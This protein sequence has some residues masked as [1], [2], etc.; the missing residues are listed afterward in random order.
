MSMNTPTPAIIAQK[1]LQSPF[2]R[3]QVDEAGQVVITQSI[4]GEDEGSEATEV[5]ICLPAIAARA[6]FNLFRR[7]VIRQAIGA[8]LSDGAKRM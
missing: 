4:P 3:V 1:H 5:V 6:L 2:L 8:R 7:R